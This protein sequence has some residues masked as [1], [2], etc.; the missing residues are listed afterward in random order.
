M[1]QGAIARTARRAVDF[2]ESQFRRQVAEREFVLNPLEQLA[3]G[4]LAGAVLDLG[5]GLGN[6]SLEAGRRGHRVLAVDGSETAIAYIRATAQAERLNVTAVQAALESYRID[7]PHDTIIAIG[8]L[9]FFQ[10][11]RALSLLRDVQVHVVPGG[12]AI[13]NVL[14]E[15]TTFLD[16][17]DPSTCSAKTN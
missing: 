5:C 1:T 11:A 4:H 3:V 13:V 10:K 15:G 17:F 16:M 6:L 14:I 8:T 7:R 2:F 9:M 12:R